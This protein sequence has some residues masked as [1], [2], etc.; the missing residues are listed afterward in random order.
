MNAFIKTLAWQVK[1]HTFLESHIPSTADSAGFGDA[2]CL[3]VESSKTGFAVVLSMQ[4]RTVGP[5]P[6]R[7][8]QGSC[9]A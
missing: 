2:S 4:A 5:A 8:G 7:A 1:E 3:T 9:G 6:F